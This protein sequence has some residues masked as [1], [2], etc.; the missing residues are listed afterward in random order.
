MPQSPTAAT[1][2]GSRIALTMGFW[3][4]ILASVLTFLF[5]ML[6]LVGVVATSFIRQRQR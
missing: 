6:A 1:P 5:V 4:A 2:N 3:S